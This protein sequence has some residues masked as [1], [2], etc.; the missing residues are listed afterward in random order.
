[1]KMLTSSVVSFQQ[2]STITLNRMSKIDNHIV[3]Q[4]DGHCCK[5]TVWYNIIEY[6]QNSVEIHPFNRPNTG[7][8]D[9]KDN[10]FGTAFPFFLILQITGVLKS[11]GVFFSFL[12][13]LNFF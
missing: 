4:R 6:K 3:K 1:M 13:V 8:V 11:S 2:R 9:G 12:N 10:I 7:E 5:H